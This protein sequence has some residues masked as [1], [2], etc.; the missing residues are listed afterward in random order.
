VD[1]L[2]ERR[3]VRE[4]YEKENPIDLEIDWEA[5]INS[6]STIQ[7]KVKR[8]KQKEI[9]IEKKAKMAEMMN[10]TNVKG[11][12]QSASVDNFLISSI[13]AKLQVLD[14]LAS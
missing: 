14:N 2:G 7:E 8:I 1:Y 12:Q 4:Q 5:E 13:K 10:P 3:K 9:M 6:Q 11:L